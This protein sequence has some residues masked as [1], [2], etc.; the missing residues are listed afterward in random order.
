MVEMPFGILDRHSRKTLLLWLI[1]TSDR[2][3]GLV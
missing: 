3:H 2:H 1:P